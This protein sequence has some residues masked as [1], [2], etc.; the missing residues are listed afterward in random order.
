L[1]MAVVGSVA[2]TRVAPATVP[3]ILL[4]EGQE[5]ARDP[6]EPSQV[7]SIVTS[8]RAVRSNGR[9]GY[10][11]LIE[12]TES[13][14][15]LTRY[16][17]WVVS[18]VG[19]VPV[20]RFWGTESGSDPAVLSSPLSEAIYSDAMV[21]AQVEERFA[22]GSRG[23]LAFSVMHALGPCFEGGPKSGFIDSLW[24]GSN[25]Q[26]TVPQAMGLQNADMLATPSLWRSVSS[27]QLAPNGG[28]IYALY[29]LNTEADGP[30]T[31]SGLAE[32][33]DGYPWPMATENDAVGGLDAVLASPDPIVSFGVA[34]ASAT[35]R[36]R[37]STAPILVWSTL[38]RTG[39]RTVSRS[40]PVSIP[41][42][43]TRTRCR[44]R[45]AQRGQAPSSAANECGT[46]MP[47]W[48]KM[49]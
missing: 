16:W 28:A 14:T 39:C 15:Q 49:D 38:T 37:R 13:V 35:T 10:A 48:T 24:L 26:G 25:D 11:A 18:S 4:R 19:E 17:P 42:A 46:S 9:S 44:S 22:F 40:G 34:P 41:T 33:A 6:T 21:P 5:I 23:E 29:A 45:L 47:T 36:N 8:V 20:P 7:D 27:P 12:S 2:L 31:S 43:H 3:V 1:F 32:F 30:T